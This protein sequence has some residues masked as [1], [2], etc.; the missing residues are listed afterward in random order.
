[1]K[2]KN[3]I[4]IPFIAMRKLRGQG[5]LR[6]KLKRIFDIYCDHNHSWKNFHK[7]WNY[8]NYRNIVKDETMT[9]YRQAKHFKPAD[10]SDFNALQFFGTWSPSEIPI[11]PSVLSFHSTGCKEPQKIQKIWNLIE[12]IK[13]L[14]KDVNRR[15]TQINCLVKM[16]DRWPDEQKWCKEGCKLGHWLIKNYSGY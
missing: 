1:M 10:S 15:M 2:T 8:T 6:E 12:K 11:L 7:I 3:Q 14:E 5:L 4:Y 9:K 13:K 16:R